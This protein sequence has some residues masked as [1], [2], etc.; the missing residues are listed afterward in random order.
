[1][2]R[3]VAQVRTQISATKKGFTL[4]ELLAVLAIISFA[5]AAFGLNGRTGTDTAKFR[6]ILVSTSAAITDTRIRAMQGFAEEVFL[7]DTKS[8]V[9]GTEKRRIELPEGVELKATVAQ[10]ERLNNGNVGIRFFPEGTSTGGT[11][12]FTHRGKTFEIR[13]NWLTGNVAIQPI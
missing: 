1:M 2:A 6:A 8:R 7:I 9:I 12:A 4:V 3:K 13:V 11:L 10:S 5:V